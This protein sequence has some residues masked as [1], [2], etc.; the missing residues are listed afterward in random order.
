MFQLICEAGKRDKILLPLGFVFFRPSVDW[1]VPTPHPQYG[2]G[3]LLCWGLWLKC[4]SHLKTPSQTHP[5]V[6]FNL[7]SL[8]QVKL[9]HKINYYSYL[10]EHLCLHPLKWMAKDVTSKDQPTLPSRYIKVEDR[11]THIWI[12]KN[13]Q[14]HRLSNDRIFSTVPL[15]LVKCSKCV[16]LDS[17]VKVDLV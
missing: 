4:S 13:S 7:S 5:E 9:P 17:D 11:V 2:K 3:H 8:W 15:L 6:V 14:D 16:V 10:S 12:W 1:I